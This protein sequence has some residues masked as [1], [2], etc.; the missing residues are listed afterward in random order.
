MFITQMHK[1]EKGIGS[2]MQD[3]ALPALKKLRAGEKQLNL[4]IQSEGGNVIIVD[5]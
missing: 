4:H 1:A 5:M 3:T 2:P